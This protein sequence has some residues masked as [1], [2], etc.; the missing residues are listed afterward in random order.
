MTLFSF[1]SERFQ[2]RR[3]RERKKKKR[4]K[5]LIK[6]HLWGKKVRKIVKTYIVSPFW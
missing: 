1:N 6:I 4:Q 5:S 2:R 3:G